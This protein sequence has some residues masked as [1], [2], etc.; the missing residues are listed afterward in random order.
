[1]FRVC[2]NFK[3]FN[4]SHSVNPSLAKGYASDLPLIQL[5]GKLS[6]SIKG[7]GRT[8]ATVISGEGDLLSYANENNVEENSTLI[9]DQSVGIEIQPDAVSFRT[10][11]AD[12]TPMSIRF[13]IDNDEF[14]LDHPT[15]GFS[16][17]PE[18][19]EDIRQ[20]KVACFLSC[21]VTKSISK[22][23]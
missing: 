9:G 3:L 20:G 10:L 6:V 19:I 17:I 18:A 14:D 1:V 2:K 22:S 16:S 7:V 13:P 21:L 11:S 15:E 8:R 12:T 23:I 4:G 5:G